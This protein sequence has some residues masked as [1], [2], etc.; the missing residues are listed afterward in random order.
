M[1]EPCMHSGRAMHV[2]WQGMNA[3]WQGYARILAEPYMSHHI[4]YSTAP[5]TCYCHS[6]IIITK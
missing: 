5:S 3:S 6:N 4:Y 1:A 2:S